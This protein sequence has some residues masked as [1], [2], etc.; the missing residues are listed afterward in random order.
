MISI[1]NKLKRRSLISVN[2]GITLVRQILAA[3]AQLAIVALIARELGAEGNGL[4]AMAVLVPALMANF[5]N[6]GVGAATVYYIGRGEHSAYQS[7]IGNLQLAS[8]LIIMGLVLAVPAFYFW[9][10]A[11]LPGIPKELIYTGMAAFPLILLTSYL[12]TILQGKEDFKSFNLIT[13]LPAYVNLF[14]LAVFLY[15]LPS[16]GDVTGALIAYLA[17]HSCGLISALWLVIKKSPV[18][19]DTLVPFSVFSRRVLGYGLRAHLSNILAFINYRADV[20]LVNFFLSPVS[21]GV[22]VIAVQFAEKLWML[23][24]AVSTV[25]LPRLSAMQDKP[26]ARLKLSHKG[27]FLVSMATAVAAGVAA[28]AI[29][30]LIKP[31]FGEEYFDVIPAFLWLI[32]GIVAGAGSRIYANCI[33]AAG[34][35]QWNMYSSLVVLVCNLAG[36]II[37]IP[38]YGIAGAAC[39]TSIAY[40]LNA[41]IKVW[42][43][44]KI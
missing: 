5:I 22:Y 34:K 39:A 24:Q 35:P 23:S 6:M 13:L 11:I 37:L 31:V 26:D 18:T 15:L 27:A 32:P 33:A 7:M 10:N 28:L 8:W 44:R 20:F 16:G 14:T 3:L 42:L 1:I 17:G 12:S 9:G 4:Y 36:N 19:D 41:I 25:L 40:C 43:V 2:I 21:A 38:G 29:Y 30:W